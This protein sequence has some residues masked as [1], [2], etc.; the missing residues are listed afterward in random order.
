M[1]LRIGKLTFKRQ[2]TLF[3]VSDPSDIDRI[4]IRIQPLSTN[5]IRIQAKR[6]DPDP[7]KF[8]NRIRIQAIRPDPDADISVLKVLHLF[9]D[10]FE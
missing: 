2:T 10:D 7:E 3:R 1:R 6:T 5:W 4:R 8:E 9:Y